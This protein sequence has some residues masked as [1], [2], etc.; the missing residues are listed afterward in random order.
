M[1]RD[2]DRWQRRETKLR[3]QLETSGARPVK[4][5][6]T[7]SARS[8]STSRGAPRCDCSAKVTEYRTECQT[9]RKETQVLRR[10]LEREIGEDV[11]LARLLAADSKWKG[12]AEQVG[13]FV[14]MAG[15]ESKR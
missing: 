6:S 9:L 5:A 3:Q 14:C 10:L 12:R 7:T 15:R 4:S 11:P 1:E 2:R 8:A 13:P